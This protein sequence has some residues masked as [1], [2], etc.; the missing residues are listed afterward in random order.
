MVTATLFL[1]DINTG[2]CPSRFGNL[3]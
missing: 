1:A 3:R 2:T